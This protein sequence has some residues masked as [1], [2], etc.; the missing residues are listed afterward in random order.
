LRRTILAGEP[1]QTI[2]EGSWH[3]SGMTRRAETVNRL[4]SAGVIFLEH[5]RLPALIES[6]CKGRN[7][8]EGITRL[9]YAQA[10]ADM[11]RYSGFLAEDVDGSAIG[12]WFGP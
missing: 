8:L 5:D 1:C 12:Y 2:F 3:Y 9:A 10:M 6:E 11:V 7:N 4:K